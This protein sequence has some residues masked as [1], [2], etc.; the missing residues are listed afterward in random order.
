MPIPPYDPQHPVT[1]GVEILTIITKERLTL[2]KETANSLLRISGLALAVGLSVLL[3]AF[4]DQAMQLALLGYPGIFLVSMLSSATIAVPMPG[5]AV[6]FAM[7]S[8]FNPFAIALVAGTGAAIG[9]MTGYIA[10]VSGQMIIKRMDTYERVAPYIKRFGPWAMFILATIPNPL[11]DLAAMA[12][13]AL[14]MS[15]WRFFLAE[16][17]GQIIKAFVFAYAGSVSLRWF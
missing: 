13:G 15:V 12:A 17:A 1:S 8:V 10:G 5:L 7:G 3:Y 14:K 4:R 2:S 16:W 9:E 11:F 6:V